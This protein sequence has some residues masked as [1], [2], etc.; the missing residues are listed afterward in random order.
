MRISDRHIP[1]LSRKRPWLRVFE[2]F[3]GLVGV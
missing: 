2:G 1:V 3:R